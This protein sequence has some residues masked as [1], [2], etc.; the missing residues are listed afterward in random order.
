[1]N[2]TR[3][4]Q[5]MTDRLRLLFRGYS[6]PNKSG[7]LQEVQVFRQY[8][9]QPEGLT[10]ADRGQEGLKHYGASDFDSNFPCVIVKVLEQTDREER[11]DDGSTVKVSILTAIYDESKE[12]QGYIDILNMQEKIREYL[13]EYRLLAER[14]LLV[15][16]LMSRLIESES[17]P[18]YWGEQMMSYV[19]A[20]PV[21]GMDWIQ[22]V[23]RLPDV[24]TSK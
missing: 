19:T 15:M 20:R 24:L 2:Q 1:M 13:L 22:G 11:G 21:M 17:W 5:D 6:L 23:H 10:F 16:P 12:C 18:V 9:P 14:Y 8:L 3:L 4:L 7:T